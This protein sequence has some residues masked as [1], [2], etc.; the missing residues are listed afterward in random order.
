MIQLETFVFT[1]VNFV[2]TMDDEE[3]R[4]YVK[5]IFK[6]VIRK[7]DFYPR[8]TKRM[9]M[10]E[11]G[12]NLKEL[13]L[14]LCKWYDE[15]EQCFDLGLK[16]AL[17]GYSQIE[18]GIGMFIWDDCMWKWTERHWSLFFL[19]RIF[20]LFNSFKIKMNSLQRIRFGFTHKIQKGATVKKFGAFIKNMNNECDYWLKHPFLSLNRQK[21][22]FDII[23]EGA[24]CIESDNA[25]WFDSEQWK[26]HIP[27]I[28]R[29]S[30]LMRP[31]AVAQFG[32][33]FLNKIKNKQSFPS[34]TYYIKGGEHRE[35]IDYERNN[36]MYD[37][38]RQYIMH[39]LLSSLSKG[40][41]K[42][43]KVRKFVSFCSKV[44][45]DMC[46]MGTL[47]SDFDYGTKKNGIEYDRKM[48]NYL[49][50]NFLLPVK[51]RRIW[52]MYHLPFTK[53][54]AYR[55]RAMMVFDRLHLEYRKDCEVCHAIEIFEDTKIEPNKKYV[56]KMY[57]CRCCLQ[58]VCS[59]RCQKIAWNTKPWCCELHCF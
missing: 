36:K 7:I 10:R 33:D 12:R 21:Y 17:D 27:F 19:T 29:Y 38:P 35:V 9:L 20:S 11:S 30:Q 24:R 43:E 4:E 26:C 5:E 47:P 55:F 39:R 13:T 46:T 8:N 42:N 28:K 16:F 58:F 48:R 25:L 40:E 59:R 18:Q 6:I 45:Y 53:V 1:E 22:K 56:D 50:Q 31:E 49:Y 57:H 34:H 44:I 54:S 23:F 41:R 52:F 32:L 51:M 37:S 3:A 14:V 2:E 15:D